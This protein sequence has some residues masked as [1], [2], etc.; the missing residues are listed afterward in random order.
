MPA[1]V[2]RIPE[3]GVEL[4]SVQI[5]KLYD[6]DTQA[7]FRQYPCRRDEDAGERHHP[8]IGGIHD[9]QHKTSHVVAKERSRTAL[10]D[11]A[12]QKIERVTRVLRSAGDTR[13]SWF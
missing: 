8:I 3:A 13:A 10:R 5:A 6:R 9:P 12:S 4:P 1:S 11:Q 7:D 2:R